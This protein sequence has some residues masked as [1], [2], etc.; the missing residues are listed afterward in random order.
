MEEF[1][2]SLIVVLVSGAAVGAVFLLAS[3]RERET[4][5]RLSAY[6]AE[7]GWTLEAVR[8]RLC[9]AFVIHAD[10]WR[11][12]AGVDSSDNDNPSG[13][14]YTTAYTQWES[15]PCDEGGEPSL[16]LG[17]VA[18]GSQPLDGRMLSFLSAMGAAD[19]EGMHA[20]ELGASVD[21]R[22]MM[23]A[24]DKRLGQG[25][26]ADV[27]AMLGDWP[28]AWSLRGSVGACG[29]RLSV[30]GKRLSQPRELDRLIE[31]GERLTERFLNDT[32]PARPD[33]KESP[34]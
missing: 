17:T 27:S 8:Q 15:E 26:A 7:H 13:S 6:C 14:L 3:R 12:T 2:T 1:L 30:P 16:W 25:A 10:G 29:V 34:P 19:T 24:R 21:K 20:V 22:F 32:H 5:E 23:V 11:L 31:L 4:R 28:A 33:E 9:K 18:G